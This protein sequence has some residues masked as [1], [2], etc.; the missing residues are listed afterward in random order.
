MKI[1]SLIL[2]LYIIKLLCQKTMEGAQI[3]KMTV[4]HDSEFTLVNEYVDL[5]VLTRIAGTL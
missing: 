1:D 4:N 3:M 2:R 5:L